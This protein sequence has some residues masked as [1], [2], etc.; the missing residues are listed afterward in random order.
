MELRIAGEKDVLHP[1]PTHPL[2]ARRN[3]GGAAH[4]IDAGDLVR[5]DEIETQDGRWAAVQSVTPL[6]GL[7]TVYP[8]TRLFSEGI[9]PSAF[10]VDK[11]HWLKH[12][13]QWTLFEVHKPIY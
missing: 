1:T 6:Q 8:G 10:P 5:G 3:A 11:Q 12:P 4:W 13:F 2:W 9:L 7:A